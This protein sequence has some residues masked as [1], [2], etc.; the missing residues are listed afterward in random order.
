MRKDEFEAKW[1]QARGLA[2][3]WWGKLSDDDLDRVAGNFEQLL[4]L[5]QVKYGY[6]RE[7][8]EKEFNGRLAKLEA[9]QTTTVAPPPA[10]GNGELPNEQG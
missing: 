9:N 7:R 4:A 6:T 5:M 3:Q 2:K 8:F 1:T 10:Q